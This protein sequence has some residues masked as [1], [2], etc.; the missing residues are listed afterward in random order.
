[1]K[2]QNADAP[3]KFNKDGVTVNVG[4]KFYDAGIE[5]A[6]IGKNISSSFS[7]KAGKA[8]EFDVAVEIIAASFMN[9]K[10]LTDK[11]IQDLDYG[12]ETVEQYKD[13]MLQQ[14]KYDEDFDHYCDFID[15]DLFD[16]IFANSVFEIDEAE[17]EN[18]K[19]LWR[20]Q[21]EELPVDSDDES[22]ETLIKYLQ[23]KTGSTSTD[24]DELMEAL[25]KNYEPMFKKNIILI[26]IGKDTVPPTEEEFEALI[27]ESK[28]KGYDVQEQMGDYGFDNYVDDMK[29][30]YGEEVLLET[31]RKQFI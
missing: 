19:R 17:F 3:K 4:K 6:L 26:E 14:Y 20:K 7:C 25:E 1:M 16:Y 9:I 30:Q 2:C 11:N 8:E 22:E 31:I 21:A 24:K 10:P 5:N 18:K 27:A 13:F 23:F 29:L 28:E 12:F 15:K